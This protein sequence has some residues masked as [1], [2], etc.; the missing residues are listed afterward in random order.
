ME[1]SIASQVD[2][3]IGNVIQMPRALY[4]LIVGAGEY[5]RIEEEDDVSVIDFNKNVLIIEQIKDR[6]DK[7]PYTNASEDLWKTIY[8]WA[9]DWSKNNSNFT[10][11]TKFI[12]YSRIKG[13]KKGSIVEKIENACSVDE[14]N[15]AYEFIKLNYNS[16]TEKNRDKYR[17]FI[18]DEKNKEIIFNI[19]RNFKCLE[20]S[21]TLGQDLEDTFERYFSDWGDNLNIYSKL[22]FNWFV[23]KVIDE[24]TKKIN[25]IEYSKTHFNDFIYGELVG[26]N[27]HIPLAFANDIPQYKFETIQDSNFIKQLNLIKMEDVNINKNIKDFLVWDTTLGQDSVKGR[28]T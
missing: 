14:I 9:Y 6:K 12:L 23:K 19:I 27:K 5:V 20:P 11:D 1:K 15:E 26:I 2:G 22:T 7:N 25:L 28:L 21:K 10:N 8:N 24:E 17:P 18:L 16:N 3:F 4:Y 13:F